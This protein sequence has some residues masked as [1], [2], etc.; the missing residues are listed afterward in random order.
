MNNA[1]EEKF[2]E[3]LD[4]NNIPYWYADQS[5]ESFSPAL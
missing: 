2:Q 3:W 4:K 1:A 5:L